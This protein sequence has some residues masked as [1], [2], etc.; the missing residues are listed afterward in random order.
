M[1]TPKKVTTK[2]SVKK[3][4]T[5]AKKTVPVRSRPQGMFVT[6]STVLFTA[7]SIVFVLLVIYRYSN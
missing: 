5:R 2:K 3:T 6:A 1:S 4:T 7:L